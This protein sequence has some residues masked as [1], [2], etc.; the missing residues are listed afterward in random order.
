MPVRVAAAAAGLAVLG[1]LAL[2]AS[3]Q[4]PLTDVIGVTEPPQGGS[5]PDVATDDAGNFVVVWQAGD[6]HGSGVFARRFG[7]DGVALAPAFQVNSTTTNFQFQPSVAMAP[8]GEFVVMWVAT[9]SS[10]YSAD[11][12]LFVRAYDAAGQATGEELAVETDVA[13][14]TGNPSLAMDRSGAFLVVWESF[15]R[16]QGT[17]L[18]VLARHFDVTGHPLG[19]PFRVS[20][21]PATRSQG[22]PGA[23][24]AAAGGFVVV[25]NDKVDNYGYKTRSVG[26]TQGRTFDPA[27]LPR[28]DDIPLALPPAPW[29]S[30]GWLPDVITDSSGNYL[31]T[32]NGAAGRLFDPSLVPRDRD[33][34]VSMDSGYPEYEFGFDFAPGPDGTFVAVGSRCTYLDE[35]NC[36]RHRI[37]GRR[38]NRTGSNLQPEFLVSA[39]TGPAGASRVATSPNG[40]F[41]VAWQGPGGIRARRF[42]WE[43]P[44]GTL[45]GTVV[46]AASGRPIPDAVIWATGGFGAADATGRFSIDLAPGVGSARATA[47]GYADSAPASVTVVAGDTTI[48]DFALAGRPVLTFQAVTVN[49]PDGNQNGLAD[50]NERFGLSVQVT[51]AGAASATS[52]AATL[53][54]ATA[55][56]QVLQGASPYPDVAAA[57]TAANLVPFVVQT[58]PAFLSGTRIAFTLTVTTGQGTFTL[59]FELTTGRN[60]QK[61]FDAGGLEVVPVR[62]DQ[63]QE[64][65]IPVS[66]LSGRI[67][68]V[69]LRVHGVPGDPP[70][71]AGLV[72]QTPDGRRA[73]LTEF[74]IPVGVLGTDC[75]ASPNDVTFDAAGTQVFGAARTPYVG[76]FL[77]RRLADLVG[78]RPNGVWK[79]QAVVSV[80]APTIRCVRLVV[81][82]AVAESG[83]AEEVA[84]AGVVR[85]ADT[86]APVAGAALLTDTGFSAVTDEDGRYRMDVGSG[87]HVI[88]A[89]APGYSDSQ[90]TVAAASGTTVTDVSI[91]PLIVSTVST[92][93]SDDGAGGNG[94]GRVDFDEAFRLFVTLSN[95][96]REAT[97][98]TATLSTA[99]PGVIVARPRATYPTIPASGSA[100]NVTPFEVRAT[101][102]FRTG[103][104]IEFHLALDS[105][106]G[107]VA[108]TFALP[109]GVPAGAPLSVAAAGPVRFDGGGGTVY[110]PLEVSGLTS[111]VATVEVALHVRHPDPRSISLV[112]H[113]PGWPL[114]PAVRLRDSGAALPGANLGTD[115]PADGND[116]TF[117]EDASLWSYQAVAPAV[118]RYHP[119]ESFTER[120]GGLADAA[121][122]GTWRIQLNPGG[123]PSPRGTLECAALT[124]DTFV[125]AGADAGDLLFR[126]GV[127]SGLLTSWAAAT[128]DAGDLSVAPEAALAATTRGLKV[129]VDDRAPLWVH[130]DTPDAEGRYRARFYLDPN[131]FDP[132]EATGKNRAIVLRAFQ[133]APQ[134]RLIQVVLRRA[135]GQYAVRGDV[136]LDDE[137][138]AS[139]PFVPITDAPHLIELDWRKASAPGANDG[140]FELLVDGVSAGRLE[141]LDN[142]VRAI[143]MV[144]L[145][146]MS[147]K[148]GA[149]GTLYLDQFESR[150][151]IAIGPH[152]P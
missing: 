146:A 37:H 54:T 42:A 48:Q 128:T 145:G 135:G 99:S 65:A 73:N 38:L 77:A 66:G 81:T 85:D 152:V 59:P 23:G 126:D 141:G 14:T 123:F 33:F 115:C 143:D 7:P 127:E 1:L 34:V 64:I 131:G 31:V 49:D 148:A 19:D 60:K 13:R 58:T 121:V 119:H 3:A 108:T 68:K 87:T 10:Q 139:T 74:G 104:P 67:T 16:V 47:P 18:D 6:G 107:T 2:A 112:L 75:P 79:L 151:A 109:T 24:A 124:I 83:R 43:S 137:A 70:G 61:A 88:T 150:R 4:T 136:R 52:V 12:Q 105:E 147:L 97:G 28:M 25:W 11:Q 46:D 125:S 96:G 93:V 122:N 118:G 144:R 134:Q 78:G 8:T 82:T 80:G 55:Q 132:G 130:D 40:D 110:M 20:S 98:V 71:M 15:Q 30:P 50:F 26:A 142:D 22:R 53:S 39:E 27:A 69:Q 32:G 76:S 120:F 62:F 102:G 5:A 103:R 117:A 92:L 113:R 100:T 133:E 116:T 36:Y 95:T 45:E 51:N 129:V 86:G 140:A 17:P 63:P 56:V 21:A 35:D 91:T 114:V 90:A 44:F 89:S 41:V 84:L 106:Q 72:L 111:A 29:W 138:V 149:A 101:R 94:S 9:A 57:A